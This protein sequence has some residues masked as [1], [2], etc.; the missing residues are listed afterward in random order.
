MCVTVSKE[1]WQFEASGG[2]SAAWWRRTN[3]TISAFG[4]LG[5]NP[6]PN[7]PRNGLEAGCCHT[8]H[9]HEVRLCKCWPPCRL[10]SPNYTAWL[11]RPLDNHV[12]LRQLSRRPGLCSS[13]GETQRCAG[14]RRSKPSQA[15]REVAG[16]CWTETDRGPRKDSLNRTNWSLSV[17]KNSGTGSTSSVQCIGPRTNQIGPRGPS[18]I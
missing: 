8:Y 17:L 11:L 16:K 10:W 13:K 18:Y 7:R 1:T 6:N 9:P 4:G 14:P 3:S 12:P 15:A 2:V 5:P